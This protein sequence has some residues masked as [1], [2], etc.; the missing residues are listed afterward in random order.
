MGFGSGIRKKPIP[1]PGSRGQ[2]GTGFRIR[3]TGTMDPEMDQDQVLKLRFN[4]NADKKYTFQKF[5][6]YIYYVSTVYFRVPLTISHN[7]LSCCRVGPANADSGIQNIQETDAD[8][9]RYG[10]YN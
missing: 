2:K 8:Y 4:C 7:F 10:I 6:L 9:Y 3:N 1:D 5:P